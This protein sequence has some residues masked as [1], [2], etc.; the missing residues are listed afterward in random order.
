MTTRRQ[1][2]KTLA[3]TAA[4]IGAVVVA[5]A[6]V[7]GGEKRGR[8]AHAV[9]YDDPIVCKSRQMGM[10]DGTRWHLN[11]FIDWDKVRRENQKTKTS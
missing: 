9:I 1:F 2:L 6:V 11:N 7:R 5:P 3:A 10:T 4:G 8:T